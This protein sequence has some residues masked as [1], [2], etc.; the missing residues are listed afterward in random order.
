MLLVR[1]PD[2]IFREEK[3]DV[4]YIEFMRGR[5]ARHPDSLYERKML[6][7]WLR[8]HLPHCRIEPL[9]PSENS[10]WI[11]GG[12]FGR[13]RIAFDDEGLQQFC[14]RWENADGS[15]ID[16]RFMLYLFRY[17]DWLKNHPDPDG[18]FRDEY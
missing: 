9:A 6:I 4:F 5:E 16:T 14:K 1:T 7:R 11:Q 17:E 3:R 18:R 2:D 15:S 10:G 13:I 12:I 8:K